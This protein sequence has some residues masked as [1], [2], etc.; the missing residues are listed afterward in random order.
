[1][2]LF[3]QGLLSAPDDS[4]PE[5]SPDDPRE[6]L[7]R[8]CALGAGGQ[9]WRPWPLTHPGFSFSWSM[10][11]GGRKWGL[12]GGLAEGNSFS[13]F[14]L[15]GQPGLFLAIL[16]HSSRKDRACGP[17][18]QGGGHRLLVVKGAGRLWAQWASGSGQ[19]AYSLPG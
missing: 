18:P 11:P 14:P 1:M 6:A 3:L 8:R 10:S 17:R 19:K 7:E 16:C 15:P 2:E 13:S 5:P 12:E 9:E 4:E